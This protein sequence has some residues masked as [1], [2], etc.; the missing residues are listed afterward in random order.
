MLNPAIMSHKELNPDDLPLELIR[1]ANPMLPTIRQRAKKVANLQI[2]KLR[3]RI[4]QKNTTNLLGQLVCDNDRDVR[5]L[6]TI[7]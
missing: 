1:S 7:S 2:P 5:T 6:P 4:V 3:S